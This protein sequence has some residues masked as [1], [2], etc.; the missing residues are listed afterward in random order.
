MRRRSVLASLG[1][2]GSAGCLR[3]SNEPQDESSPSGTTPTRTDESTSGETA[4]A[5]SNG[6]DSGGGGQNTD[7]SRQGGDADDEVDTGVEF[8]VELV[9]TWKSDIHKLGSDV[10]T[11]DGDFFGGIFEMLRIRPDGSVVFRFDE[12]D[13]GYNSTIRSNWR[14][15]LQADESGTYVGAR[16]NDEEQGARMYSLDP[17]TGRQQWRFEEPND[18][19]H[20]LI[21]ATARVDDLLVYASQSSGS[22]SDQ[23]P[24]V[25]A[26]DVET[27]SEQ[28]RLDYS[29]GEFVNQLVAHDGRLFVQQLSE[30]DVY[31]IA[32]RELLEERTNR[33]TGFEPMVKHD[34]TLYVPGETV[35]AIDLPSVD[36]QW[37]TETGYEVNTK[38][39]IGESAVFLGTESGFVAGFDRGTGEQVWESRVDGVIGHPPVVEDGLVWVGNERGGLAAY[40]EQTGEIAYSE[41]VAPDFAFAVQDGVLVDSARESAFDIRRT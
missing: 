40:T 8:E 18:G 41:D 17:K 15:A 34:G 4:A 6:G 37:A 16:G 36:V 35:Q 2:I 23:E 11:A 27:G 30:I 24:I 39:A 29:G 32:T 25:R 20:N 19:L 3:L 5:G 14:N 31:D 28:W 13:D 38:P 26:L 22:G 7:T 9:P 12:F 1:A 10:V 33:S 21:E